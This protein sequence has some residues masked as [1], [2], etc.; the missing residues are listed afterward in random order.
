MDYYLTY[1]PITTPKKRTFLEDFL[2]DLKNKSVLN[3]DTL[4]NNTTNQAVETIKDFCLWV[5]KHQDLVEKEEQEFAQTLKESIE[6]SQKLNNSLIFPKRSNVIYETSEAEKIVKSFPVDKILN[7]IKEATTPQEKIMYM[8]FAFGGRKPS[9]C[10]HMFVE[11][12]KTENN[13]I[14]ITFGHPNRSKINNQTREEYL[15]QFKLVPRNKTQDQGLYM[16]W[17]IGRF[18]SPE[19]LESEV[20]FIGAVESYLIQLHKEHM[21]WR[22][23]FTHHPYYFCNEFG[24][25]LREKTLYSKFKIRCNEIGLED[26][27]DSGV[28]FLGLRNFYVY[29]LTKALELDKVIVQRLIGYQ[30]SSRVDKYLVNK[31][32]SFIEL[33]K[34]NGVLYE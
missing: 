21:T 20:V 30:K 13:Q 1:Q 7:L 26:G 27:R 33:E 10:L 17:N 18:Q 12:F 32:D 3:W 8:L 34:L 22:K 4:T 23:N 24:E 11:D 6:F 29:Y 2:K 16:G 5:V 25:P 15:K 31:E 19:K 9:E 14:K 28:H